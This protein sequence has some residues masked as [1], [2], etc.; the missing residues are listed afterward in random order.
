MVLTSLLSLH[1][2]LSALYGQAMFRTQ[3]CALAP[4]LTGGIYDSASGWASWSGVGTTF[5]SNISSLIDPACTVTA[6]SQTEDASGPGIHA[7]LFTTAHT[8]TAQSATITV[9]AKR[10]V[11]TRNFMINFVDQTLANGV[12][13]GADLSN[14][15]INVAAAVMGTWTGASGTVSSVGSGWCKLTATATATAANPYIIPENLS[16]TSGSYA[17]DSTSS[18]AFWGID[19]R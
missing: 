9:Y 1:I 4:Q 17:G 2:L 10:L 7:S 6:A 16:G 5:A 13:I 8:W 19:V 12:S 18:V 3:N 11:G 15:S 14:C